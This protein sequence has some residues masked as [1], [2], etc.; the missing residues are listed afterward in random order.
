[1]ALT[2]RPVRP[3]SPICWR[4]CSSSA[5]RGYRVEQLSGGTRQKLNL[6]LALMHDPE[7]LVLDEL[8]WRASRYSR[9]RSLS[10]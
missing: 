9:R 8:G 6:E 2:S 4:S 7:L 10:V 5:Y 1:M 3:R